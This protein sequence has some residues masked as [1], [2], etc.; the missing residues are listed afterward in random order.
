MK[1]NNLKIPNLAQISPHHVIQLA[2][3]FPFLYHPCMLTT[4]TQP[5]RL[6]AQINTCYM[7]RSNHLWRH[8]KLLLGVHRVGHT[9][10][11]L[12]LLMLCLFVS[13]VVP[14]CSLSW[15]LTGD[16]EQEG[17]DET[18]RSTVI[19]VKNWYLMYISYD[20]T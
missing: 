17:H 15:L 18:H 7:R 19:V 2:G 3:K 12:V 16:A 11:V 14:K 1:F 5:F 9:A 20:L 10:A 13:Y 4:D 8:N 6:Q